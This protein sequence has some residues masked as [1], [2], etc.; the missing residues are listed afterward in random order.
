M[1]SEST[2]EHGYVADRSS[3][4]SF[5]TTQLRC[6]ASCRESRQ[7]SRQV[8]SECTVLYTMY[9]PVI[10]RSPL[11][12]S[13]SRQSDRAHSERFE[14]KS[15]VHSLDAPAETWLGGRLR[16][17]PVAH[18]IDG[19]EDKASREVVAAQCRHRSSTKRLA[20]LR[21]RRARLDSPLTTRTTQCGE[22]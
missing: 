22:I 17:P 16:P 5:R 21:A 19:R 15:K 13:I 12:L 7:R 10:L 20:L 9:H 4:C 2:S 3:L 8:R 11:G 14:G 6:T 18:R 1:T